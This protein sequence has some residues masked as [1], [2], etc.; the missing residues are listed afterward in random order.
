MSYKTSVKSKYIAPYMGSGAT[1]AIQSIVDDYC[2][3]T[4]GFSKKPTKR[5]MQNHL[6]DTINR[7]AE[8]AKLFYKLNT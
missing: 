6:K 7:E 8:S 5:Q 1:W 3:F 4:T 2:Q